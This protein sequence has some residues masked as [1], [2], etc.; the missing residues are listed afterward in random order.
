MEI[1]SGKP[2]GKAK[3][4]QQMLLQHLTLSSSYCFSLHRIPACK[5]S[6]VR[7]DPLGEPVSFSTAGFS[8]SEQIMGSPAFSF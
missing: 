8:S 6:L 7:G 5:G 2:A 4:H 3:A 1:K